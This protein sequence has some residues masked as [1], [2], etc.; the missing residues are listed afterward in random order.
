MGV[1]ELVSPS[2]VSQPLDKRL[3]NIVSNYLPSAVP[4]FLSYRVSYI[5]M[6]G[7]WVKYVSHLNQKTCTRIFIAALFLTI[8]TANNASITNSRGNCHTLNCG[9]LWIPFRLQQPR[10]EPQ[11][12]HQPGVLGVQSFRL[13]ILVGPQTLIIHTLIYPKPGPDIPR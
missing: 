12:N 13:T 7:M 2:A 1:A 3:K 9:M 6:R 4:L 5:Q 8:Q 11:P 10:S